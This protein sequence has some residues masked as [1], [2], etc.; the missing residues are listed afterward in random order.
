MGIKFIID[1]SF[2]GGSIY[3]GFLTTWCY[4][5]WHTPVSGTIERSYTIP[6][7]YFLQNP[8]LDVKDTLNF[9]NSQPFFGHVATRHVFIINTHK[10]RVGRVAVIQIGMA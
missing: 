7:S 8:S 2:A 4:H 10:E 9:R 3:Q 1:E 6:G 5:R